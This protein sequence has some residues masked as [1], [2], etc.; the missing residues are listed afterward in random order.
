MLAFCLSVFNFA[1]VA[2]ST[3]RTASAQSEESALRALVEKYFA[4]NG[5]SDLEGVLALWSQK[6]PNLEAYRKSLP[7]QFANGDVN[8]SGLVVSRV[9]VEN[10]KASLRAAITLSSIDQKSQQKSD[11]QLIRTFE[12]VKEA[13]EW[14]VWR[15]APAAEDLAVALS[16]AG[17]GAER[18]ALLTEERELATAELGPALLAQGGRLARQGNYD[19]ARE[20]QELAFEVS[21]RSGDK[22]LMI[23]ALLSIGSTH[24]SQGDFPKALQRY[25]QGL[26]IAEES[27]DQLGML[28]A[29][30]NIGVTYKQQGDSAN[31]LEQYQRS[32]KIAQALGDKPGIAGALNNIGVIFKLQGDYTRALEQYRQSLK[33]SEEL[34]D[35][36]IIANALKNFGNL[37]FVQGNYAQAL[38]QLQ[39]SL[40][41]MEELGDRPGIA[42]VL[43]GIG[44]VHKRQ[45]NNTQAL[46]QFQR[47]LKIAEEVGA[48]PTMATS[49]INIG[50]TYGAQGDR[51]LELEQYQ[52]SLKIAE[53]IG[54]KRGISRAL[55]SIGNIYQVRGDHAQALEKHRQSLKIIEDLNDK[56][57][58]A[59]TLNCIADA[60]QAQ[61]HHAQALQVAER[62][63]DLAQ[64]LGNL[65][66]LEIAR[67]AAGRAYL[68]LGQLDRARQAFDA[69]INSI[70]LIRAQ[71]AGGEQERQQFFESRVD[72]YQGMIE[73]LLARNDPGEALTYAERARARVLLDVFSGGRIRITKAMTGAEIEREGQLNGQL[74]SLNTQILREKQRQPADQNRLNQLDAQL[75]KARLEFEAFRTNLYLSHPE[76][77]VQ[78]NEI[79]PLSLD[80]AAN[81]IP[82]ART[83]LLEFIVTEENVY[84]F[85][86]TKETS[87]PVTLMT[88]PIRIERQ[89]LAE[90]VER[91]RRRLANRDYDYR[92]LSQELYG[93]LLKPAEEQLRNKTNLIIS[94]DRVLWDLPF[95]VLQPKEDRYLI[96]D[97]TISYA[98][99]LSVLRELQVLRKKRPSR[100]AALMLALGNPELGNQTVTLTKSILMDAELQPLPEAGK[101]VLA[102]GQ[103]YGKEHSAVYTGPAAQEEVVK[104]ESA[105]YRIFHLATHGILNDAS[106]MY[107]NLMLAQTPGKRDEDGLLEAWEIM[108]LNLNADLAVFSACET[109]RGRI[110]TGEGVIGLTWALF[111][112]GC[113]TTIVSQWKVE[114][115]STTAL[116]VEFHKR[117]KTR[118]DNP[119]SAPS[120]AECMRQ[121]SLKL[122]KDK[123]YSHPF[124][125][126][127]FVVVGDGH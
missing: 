112:A 119:H 22:K 42:G 34:G 19:R 73:L 70:E 59:E 46:E 5:K 95:Q 48:K 40:K 50:I 12:F 93:L 43:N 114:S 21:E 17:S 81:L 29:L 84:L 13:V 90:K 111:V 51:R 116:M 11:R 65:H 1:Q 120:A 102:L 49:L 61:G 80:D 63:A 25:Q 83:A 75:R 24:L 79:R 36:G 26:K 115:S 32:L 85:V 123:Q 45:G 89:L 9:K 20:I 18:E 16:N 47:S 66:S 71:V 94:P 113:P 38:E 72:P 62:A 44:M 117:Y 60:H 8:F 82:D 78:R 14:K 76:L 57:G 33:I 125:W 53:E 37:Y 31:A 124:F 126:G 104:R 64:A 28:R 109:A 52:K 2:S 108:N 106:P 39:R 41:I 35:R 6:S 96:E 58:A 100:D 77:K 86:L 110:G 54:D 3:P 101:Q 121:A 88:Y 7:Q 105:K 107:S 74:V 98:P 122:M 87:A 99:S 118:F 69:S 67:H 4:A 103:L 56:E 127:A 23:G 30:N 97:A 92:K 10:E 27:G 68:S 15:Y 55:G 91:F